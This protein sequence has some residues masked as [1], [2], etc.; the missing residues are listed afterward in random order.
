MEWA[1]GDAEAPTLTPPCGGKRIF[2]L[3]RSVRRALTQRLQQPATSEFAEGYAN[4]KSRPQ[5][6]RHPHGS[7]TFPS[8]PAERGTH[9]DMLIATA[10]DLGAEGMGVWP[11]QTS[12]ISRRGQVSRACSFLSS[13][14]R[15][16][17]PPAGMDSVDARAT[18]VSAYAI[19]AT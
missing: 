17:D 13:R 11:V 16:V 7:K 18:S 15:C 3:S 10:G 5:F 2:S 8:A 12:T 4:E 19:V 9:A 1:V 6:Q 14:K